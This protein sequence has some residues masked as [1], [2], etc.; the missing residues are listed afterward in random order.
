MH[1]TAID[2]DPVAAQMA[3]IQLSLLHIPAVIIQGNTLSM[4]LRDQW[5]TPAHVLG[6]WG[7]RLNQDDTEEETE[8]MS[9]APP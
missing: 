3:Y 1:V 4:E 8:D 7:Q 5:V 9:A 6:N 2:I